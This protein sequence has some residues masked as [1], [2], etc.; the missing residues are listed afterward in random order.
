MRQICL[1]CLC[2]TLASCKSLIADPMPLTSAGK[3]T[4]I[5]TYYTEKDIS[6]GTF[7][8]EKGQVDPGVELS[9]WLLKQ[10]ISPDE[11]LLVLSD[12]EINRADRESITNE[13]GKL[14]PSDVQFFIS[15]NDKIEA[16]Y[17]ITAR[18]YYFSLKLGDCQDHAGRYKLGC[19]TEINRQLSRNHINPVRVLPRNQTPAVYEEN[20]YRRELQFIKPKWITEGEGRK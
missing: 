5:A 19:A 1:I 18:L 20:P 3:A 14:N 7:R 6:T 8:N 13:W 11:R 12:T 9:N 2:L 15:D 4:S 10:G 16:N 17:K